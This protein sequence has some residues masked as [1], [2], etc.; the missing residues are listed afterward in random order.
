MEPL[1]LN[2]M[3]V[4]NDRMPLENLIQTRFSPRL[5]YCLMSN[6][7]VK[8]RS[9]MGQ[10]CCTTGL[11]RTILYLRN[12]FFL[13]LWKRIMKGVIENKVLNR[14]TSQCSMHGTTSSYYEP[15]LIEFIRSGREK[16]YT[17]WVC[18]SIEL[19]ILRF[20]RDERV[21][22]AKVVQKRRKKQAAGRKSERSRKG[23]KIPLPVWQPT[24]TH[25]K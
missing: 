10:L 14:K 2:A 11:I 19:S 5:L 17:E 18:V 16:N 13:Y 4:Q 3:G 1:C 15:I 12:S 8:F 25:K 20:S 9:N 24:R 6:Q 23:Y 22:Q 21:T 7:L